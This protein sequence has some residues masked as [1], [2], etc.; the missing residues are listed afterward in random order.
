MNKRIWASLDDYMPPEGGFQHVG[1]NIANHNFFRALLTY[2]RFDEYHFFLANKAHQRAFEAR[3]G[4]FLKE[5]GGTHKVR[6]F[7]RL[8]LPG[9][10]Q[11][12]DYTV[13]H[14]SDHITSFNAL[15]HLRN[16]L[17]SF[18]VTA[19]IHSLSYQSFMAKYLEMML[20]GVTRG[21]ALVCSSE[22]GK[23][24][25]ENCFREISRRCALDTPPLQMEVIP[26]GIDGTD[27]VSD[28]RARNRNELGLKEE[29]VIG[30]CFGRFSDYDKMDLF[31][32]LQAYST[33]CA[34]GCPWRL[35]LAGAVHSKSYLRMLELWVRALGLS[36]R[37]S[38]LTDL[39]EADKAGLY[40]SADFFI[41]LSDNPQETFGLT[42]LEAMAFG[43]PLL[44]SDFDGYR[45]IV[46][47]E[48]G[49]RVKTTWDECAPLVT[50]GPLMDEVT[51]HRYLAQS[52]SIDLDELAHALTFF[53][54]QPSICHDMGAA[55]RDRFLRL[56]D[57][58]V[59]IPKLESLW[60]DLKTRFATIP[61]SRESDPLGM[62]VFQCFSH[63]PSQSLRSEMKFQRTGYGAQLLASGAQYPLLSDMGSLID[64]GV[65]GALLAQTRE[66]RSLQELLTSG[67]DEP[68]R[69]RYV[70]LWMLKHGLLRQVDDG[71]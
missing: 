27:L 39:S 53:F 63:Y 17:A 40:R 25:I 66:T 5:I 33:I 1:R 69:R 52:L 70:V 55:A 26:L 12:Q 43:L 3:H 9:E 56:Y 47:T 48:V 71:T 24:V 11:R 62:N 61:C 13:F 64:H 8:D 22:S 32:L 29:E 14:Q 4:P 54:S 46:P 28:D 68:W 19:F 21:D 37:V 15:C 38:I 7:E 41:S 58:R 45:E 20:G 36:D 49:R 42:L 57:Y 67:E 59:V 30:L 31:P 35:I 23:Q 50:L 10:L 44:V 16:Q 65:V 60:V 18:P 2:G 6:L 51:Y 34:K